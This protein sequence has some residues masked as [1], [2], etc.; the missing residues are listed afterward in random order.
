[1]GWESLNI[2]NFLR[3]RLLKEPSFALDM[4]LLVFADSKL[5]LADIY[6]VTPLLKFYIVKENSPLQRYSIFLSNHFL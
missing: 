4:C 6:D 5:H 3:K 2:K 1:M